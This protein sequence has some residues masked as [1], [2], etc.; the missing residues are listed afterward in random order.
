[1]KTV[2]RSIRL[3]LKR[4][5]YEVDIWRSQLKNDRLAAFILWFALTFGYEIVFTDGEHTK[6][7][8]KNIEII[9]DEREH[10]YADNE[11]FVEMRSP[12]IRRRNDLDAYGHIFRRNSSWD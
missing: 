10:F 5:T 2:L 7:R 8:R 12:V 11:I 9:Q 1:M 3:V 6:V 4:T